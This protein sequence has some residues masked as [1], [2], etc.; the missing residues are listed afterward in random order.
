MTYLLYLMALLPATYGAVSTKTGTTSVGTVQTVTFDNPIAAPDTTCSSL[1]TF[2]AGD[3]GTSP[4]CSIS[5]STLDLIINMGDSMTPGTPTITLISGGFTDGL[6]GDLTFTRMSETKFIFSTGAAGSHYQDYVNKWTVVPANGNGGTFTYAWTYASGTGGPSLP[7]SGTTLV[8]DFN[9]WEATIGQ[10]YSVAVNMTDDNNA[11][12]YYADTGGVFTVLDSC[13]SSCDTVTWTMTNDPGTVSAT[14]TSGQGGDT[15]GCTKGAGG[16]PYQILATYATTSQGDHAGGLTLL[17]AG[18]TAPSGFSLP[19]TCGSA[20]SFPSVAVNSDAVAIQS[21][22]SQFAFDAAI[23]NRGLTVTTHYTITWTATNSGGTGYCGTTTDS[24]TCTIPADGTLTAGT[25]YA[26]TVALKLVCKSSIV[27]QDVTFTTFTYTAITTATST[28]G[29][30]QTLTFTEPMSQDIDLSDTGSD[31]CGNVLT[32]STQAEVGIGANCTMPDKSSLKIAYGANYTIGVMTLNLKIG[33]FDKYIVKSFTRGDVPSF[34]LSGTNTDKYED[35]VN[36]WSVVSEIN[37]GGA[38]L[39]YTWTY[40]SGTGGPSLAGNPTSMIFNY[41]TMTAETYNIKVVQSDTSNPH[42]SYEKE[43][44]NFKILASCTAASCTDV[45][46]TLSNDPGAFLSTTCTTGQG[47]GDIITCAKAQPGDYTITA[48]YGATSEGSNAGL[49]LL[50]TAFNPTLAFTLSSKCGSALSFPSVAVNSDAVA[51]QSSGSQFAFDAAI[52]NRGLTVTTHYTITWTATNSGGTG[53]CGTTTDSPTCTIPA[54]GTLTAGTTYAYTVALKLVCKSSIVWQDVTFTTFTY[55]A[56]TTAT[57]TV[58]SVQTLT[59]TEP[60][61]Q[62]IDLSDTGS[63]SCGNVLT[64]STQAEVGIG[65]NCTMPDKSSLKI[66]YGANYTIGVMTLNLKIGGFDKYIVKSFTRGDVPSFALSGTNTDKYEDYVNTWSVVSEINTGGAPLVYTWTYSS[67]TGGPSLAGNPTSMIF[68]YWT[69]TAETYN[70]K[71]VQSDTSNPHFSYEKETGNFKILA[72]C[73]AASC[74]DVTWTL[75]NDPGAFLST[76]CTTGQGGG[77]IITCA[78]AQPGDYT[79]TATYGATSEGSNAGLNLLST[80]FNPTLAFTLSSKCGSALS[81]P[82]V[83]VNSDAVAIQSSGSQFAFDAAITN[84][85]LTVTTHYT[86]TWTATNSGGTGYCGTT[87]DSPT[88][89][90]PADGTLT[91]GTT[92]AYTVALKLVCKSSIVWQDVTFTTFTYT[93]ITTATSTV[94]SVQTLTFTEPMSQSIALSDTGS[95]S[96]GNVLISSGVADVGTGAKCTTPTSSTLQIEY[97]N[98]YT[99]GGNLVLK[100]GGMDKWITHTFAKPTLPTVTYTAPMDGTTINQ[101]SG[102]ILMTFSITTVGSPTWLFTWECTTVPECPTTALASQTA[103]PLDLA[104]SN[105]KKGGSYTFKGTVRQSGV[106][107][108]LMTESITVTFLILLKSQTQIG[109]T[110]TVKSTG[111]IFNL[112]MGCATIFDGTDQGKLGGGA[113]CTHTGTTDTITIV[114][115][116]DTTLRSTDTMTLQLANYFESYTLNTFQ[117]GSFSS[118]ATTMKGSL[119]YIPLAET[120]TLTGG[121][122]STDCADY[123]VATPGMTAT[124]C[125]LESGGLEIVVRFA[126]SDGITVKNT[127]T[128]GDSKFSKNIYGK[129]TNEMPDFLPT[130]INTSTPA[131]GTTTTQDVGTIDMAFAITAASTKAAPGWTYSW[132]CVPLDPLASCPVMTG[133]TANPLNLPAAD[134]RYG[135]TYTITGLVKQDDTTIYNMTQSF[136]FLFLVRHKTDTQ[137]GNTI[138]I[139]SNPHIFHLAAMDCSTIFD[140][141]DKNKLGTG[142]TCTHSPPSDTITIVLGDD[143][144]LRSDSS[145]T[146]TKDQYFEDYSITIFQ[147]GSFSS[148]ATTMKGSLWYIP[149]AEVVTLTGAVSTDCADYF[150]ATTGMGAT[151]CHLESGG[152]EIVVRFASSD[153]ITG[154]NT[155]TIGDSKFNKNIYGKH[156]NQMPDFLPTMINTSTPADGTTTTQDVGT[157]IMTF[158][159]TAASTKAPPVWTYSWTC[160]PLDPLASCP[161]MTGYTAN[162]LNLPAADIRYGG[163]YTITGLVK[164][165]DTTIYN[166]T[167]SF[168]FLFLIK[169]KTDTQIGN[170]IVLQSAGHLFN[171]TGTDCTVIF[172]VTDQGLLGTG[173]TCTHVV[174]SDTITIVLGNDTSLRSTTPLTLTKDQYFEDYSITIFQ[175]GSFSSGATTMKGSLWYIPLAEVVTL[176]GAV[177]TDCAD[178]FVATTG[179]GAT[180]CHLESGGAEIVV[181]FAS[182]D[183]ITGKNTY[184]IGDSKF[185]KNIY[186]KHTNQMPDFLPTMIN[187]STPADGTTTTQDVGTIIM[188]FPITAASTKAPPVW[189]YSW[190]CVPL[191]P[192]ASCPVMTGYTANPLNL[193]AADIRY[194]GT[195]TIT[196]LV[197][198][199]DTTIY[200]MTQ[201][202]TFLFLIKMKTDTQ[203]GNT[204]VLQSAGH[205]FNLTGTACTV[206]FS[207]ADQAK[208]GTGATCTHVVNS[209]TITIVLGD[210]TTLR[211]DSSLTLT[212]NQYFEDYSITIFQSGSFSSGATTMKGSL[213]YIPLAEVVTLTGAVSTDCADYFVATTGMGATTCHLESGGAEIVVRFASSDGITGKNTYTIG[214]SKFNKNIYGKH[215]NQ[216]PDFLP[217]MINTSTPADGTTTTQDVGTIIMTFPITAASTKAPPVWTYS[218]TCVPLD[219]LA[220]CPVMTGYTAN[221]LNLPAADIRYGGTY[222]ITGLVKQDDTTIYNMTQSFT[223]LFLIKMKT[224]TQIGNTIVLQSAGHLFNLTGTACTVIFSVA[225][226]AKLGTGAT[227][228]HVVNS[229]TITIVLGDDT[230]LRSDSSLT[231]TK[232][233]YFEDYSITIFQSGSFSS[234]ATTMKGSLWYI[235]LA[236]VVT[237]TGAVSTDCADYFVATTG[238]GAT[239]CHLESGGAEIVVRFASSDG[240]TGK[241]TYTIGDSKFNKN[242]YGKHTNQMPDFLP[243]MINTSTP[244]DGTTTTQDVGTIIMTFPI[245]AA[246]TKAPPVWTYSWTCVPLDPLASCPVMTG[247]TANPLNLP[248]ADIR[249]GGTYTITGLVKQDD[250]TIYNMTQSFTFLFLIKMKTD[251]QIGNTIVLQSAG[252]LFN[253]TGTDCTVI[254]D[255]TDQGLLGTGATCTHVVNSDTITI[256]LGNDTSLRSTTPLTL[257]KDQYFEDYSITI[258]QSG[259]FSSGATTMKGSLWYIPLTEAVTVNGGGGAS[260]DCAD[261]FDAAVGMT[262]ST[263][264]LE[265]GGLEIVVRFASADAGVAAIQ[266]TYVISHSKFSKNIYGK[267]TNQMPDVVPTMTNASTP[268]DGATD[269]QDVGTV[270]MTFTITTAS[271]KAT[272]GWTYSWTCAPTPNCP[273]MTSYTANPLN[274]PAANIKYGG[275]FTI[276][277]LVKQTDTSIFNM[278]QSFS[279]LFLI[280]MKTDTQI[281]NTIVLQS[282]GHLFNLTGTACTVIFSV[283][284]QAKLG[285]GATCTHVVNSDTITIV[286]GDDTTLRSDSSL[287]L[288]KDQYF[289]D[290]SIT[291]FQSGSFSSGATT[292]KGSLWYIPLAEVVTLT[293]AVSTDC[294]DYFVATTGMG[295]TTCHLESGGAEIVVRFASSDGITGKN[296]YTIGDSKFNKNIYGK[297][298]NQ[299]PDFLPTMINTS[300]PADGTTTTQDVGTIIMT[301]PITAASTKAP[302]VW[303]YSWTCVPLDPLASCPVMTGYTANPL[304]LPAADI[305]YGGTYTITG[306]VKQDDTT[307][308]NMTQ[309]FTFLFL[310]RHKTDTQVGNTIIIK[311]NPHIFHLAAMDCSTIFDT[312]DKNKLGTGATCTHSPPSD[313]ITIVLGDDTTLRSDSSLTLTKDQYFE[314][315]SITIFQSGSFSS[316]ATTM[317]GSLW[318]I[319]LAEVVTLTGAVSTDCADYFVATT[320]MG[321]TTC[322]LES[323]GAEIVVRFASSDGITGK[324]TYTIGDS[325]FNKNIYGKHTNQ[326]P[327]FLPTMINTSTPADGTTT[328]QD[329]GTIIMTF[330][331]TA[332]STKAPPVWTY[333]WTCVP[334]DPLASCPVMT[335]YTAN[336]LNLPAA[337]IRYGGT[338]TITGLVKQDDTTIYNMTQSFTFLFLIKMKTDTQ[339][340]NTIVLQSAGHLFNL[341]GTDC[342]VIFD[343]TDQGLLGTGATCTHV[344]NSDT[345]T[346]VLGN[347]T[348]LRSTTPLTLTKDQ[349]FEDYLITIFHSGSFSSGATTMKGSLWYIPL[350][351]AVTVNGGGGASTDCADYFDAAVGM[352]DSTCV[353]ESGGLEIVVRFASADAG[354]AA[355]QNTYV[356]SH[357][358]FSKNI[359]GKHTNQMPDVVP[360]MTNA[361]TPADGATD[362]QDVGTVVMTFTITTASTK[363]TPGWTYSWTCAPLDPLA[364]CPVMT[365]YTTHPLNLPAADI[366]YGGTY[367]IT[368][369]VKQDDTTIYNMTQSFTFLFLIRM[370]TDTQIGNTIVLK[371]G[372]HL[373]NLTGTDCTVIF[374]VT[375]QGLLGTGA[376]CTHVVNSDTITIVL[377]NDTSLRS[378]TPLTLTKDQYF[379]DYLITIFHS[380]SFSSGATTMKGSLWYIP[381]TEAV[382]VNG[383]GGAS[384]DCADYFDA[385]VGMTDSTCV[386]ESGG[387]EIVVRFASADAGV[388]AIQNTYVISHSKFSKNIYGKHT[389]QMPDVV[390]T[391]TNASTPAD[392]ATDTQDVGTVVMTFSITAASTKATPSWTYSW[393]CA[394]LDP[395]ASCPVMTGYTTHPLNLPAADI[396]YGGTYTITGLVKQDDTTIYNMTQSFT[397]LFLIR[398]KTDTQIGNTIVLKSGGHLFNLTGTDCTV[399]FDITDQGLL[400]TG[401]TCT[402]VVNSDTITIVLGNDTS[403]R[404]TTPLTLTKDQYFEDY[405]ITIFHSGSFS[406]GATTMKGSLWYIPLTE[407]V[408][409]NGGGGASTDCADY[410]DAAVGMTDSTCVL[411]SGGLEIVVRFASADAGV[412]A[413]QNTYVISHSKFSKNIYGKHTNQMP[414]VVPTMTYF[415]AQDNIIITQDINNIIMT[416]TITAASTKAPPLWTYEWTCILGPECPV[417]TGYT[418]NPLTVPASTILKGGT[419]QFKVVVRQVDTPIYNMT[420]TMTTH[421][422]VRLKTQVPTGNVMVVTSSGH[423]FNLPG[424]DCSTIFDAAERTLL[425]TVISSTC[426][427]VDGTDTITIDIPDDTILTEASTID[428]ELADYFETYLIDVFQYGSFSYGVTS[429]KGSIWYIPLSSAVTLSPDD[430]SLDCTRYLVSTAGL[431]ASTC[432][433]EGGGTIIVLRFA[434]DGPSGLQNIYEILVA[435]Y[436][437]NIY[438][439]HLNPMPDVMPTMIFTSAQHLQTF[440]QDELN[441]IMKLTITAATGGGTPG[442]TYVWV[443]P[444]GPECPAMGGYTADPLDVLTSLIK[445]G[446]TYNFMGTAVQTDT[447]V[448]NMSLTMEFYYEIRLKT[449]SQNGNRLTVSTTG[450]LFNFDTF[451]CYKLFQASEIAKLGTVIPATCIHTDETDYFEII[452]PLT[453]IIDAD[454]VLNVQITGAVKYFEDYVI[455]VLHDMPS[456]EMLD[457]IIPT[458]NDHS[459]TVANWLRSDPKNIDSLVPSYA[460]IQDSGLSVALNATTYNQEWPLYTMHLDTAY[461]F[462]VNMTLANS[463]NWWKVLIINFDVTCGLDGWVVGTDLCWYC[464]DGNYSPLENERCITCPLRTYIYIYIYIYY[465][466]FL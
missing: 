191:D 325:K 8:F 20:L 363:A 327:D 27:W 441:V 173:A 286:L 40:S 6:T 74:T 271:T 416:L 276:T 233:Q 255:V 413:I 116:D 437:K 184:T 85:G 330:P 19:A 67:G 47:G 252:H 197:K 234:G 141:T 154:K 239:T 100:T 108:Y 171:L 353:L 263:C 425:G 343:V 371:S 433:L 25:T 24:P 189:T 153:G 187:T 378:T 393:T 181:R 243:T 215:T 213:W 220:S 86:I 128:I 288:T 273:V 444:V 119:W 446:G 455:D 293:G 155:Y 211:S 377:G 62:D 87:T 52:T 278:T 123:F 186:G 450:H 321:A 22:G 199:D 54:D 183:G 130:M 160:V 389:N 361:S 113:A 212:K 311:S 71:V 338:Y 326:M 37:T 223:F 219:P 264:V 53:Y 324:N 434:N 81:F 70:I 465:R 91:A 174:N 224:D 404:S 320:G 424:M 372:G 21:S 385:A 297:H 177:S 443:C 334:L 391:M 296:T 193:P 397:F 317:K 268:A 168:T 376:T 122:V 64:S 349:Y 270:V 411:E 126:S 60:M 140:T 292:M 49:N 175:S 127:Y 225:D 115:G 165:D 84:R 98:G 111:H 453:T 112:A 398:M 298:T 206:I 260:T 158:P 241:N 192:L 346:I 423:N 34:A 114:L 287:T 284:D 103:N 134:I 176:T 275:S 259:S 45:T 209:D 254:F 427:H 230:T 42:F 380:G 17:E 373:F 438:G 328:T 399:I 401:A 400:G 390:P 462:T 131:D 392:G 375:D 169:M 210:D 300:T 151:T 195:Y 322:H 205:L 95:D 347:D 18:F 345:I 31:S 249:Y 149:L 302:P 109:N 459:L 428:I 50:S 217:T 402:H 55:T 72:S 412:A 415:S 185:N 279:F 92:Y 172:D 3:L 405:L 370:K 313:T 221:P 231:L 258:F 152:A 314:D 23:T 303:T 207:V 374:D 228:T 180:T 436:N 238:M 283:A 421:F 76:T 35:Y 342:T 312:T 78:K 79:I 354:V 97:G 88:C 290:Y 182:S 463:N 440:T 329:V 464:G 301:F 358:K 366:R 1:L 422:R 281:G 277:G 248:A 451:D 396:R 56:I 454:S 142:A 9:Y 150:V 190:T 44:G 106:T 319:P 73:T 386:L 251:T 148:G 110:I 39:V 58:G 170:T 161:V 89:T 118:G 282:A 244:A 348:S 77:D 120:V 335:G 5:G 30:V 262:D 143:T 166:M 356:I 15:V 163:T 14:C 99:V 188:T 362:T 291:I 458:T 226:Q 10:G 435:G 285:T 381:L 104:T 102:N 368:G 146:L 167:Q 331:I 198:Q 222:T 310:V 269:T 295:A 121:A 227:C 41:W 299:M 159:I 245:T 432:T 272:P 246:S 388:A 337:D 232:N 61:S 395:L 253:L 360:T 135:G 430:G 289:E 235:P 445:K 13:A 63:D 274:L 145:L 409:V 369:L 11:Q 407:A 257:T 236:E 137:V 69:M 68:N 162:P 36:T 344:V 139:K 65:A 357:S 294:A 2:T 16:G 359:Y 164:Q 156:T 59:F 208:L 144:T 12:F 66:A 316:G 83:A 201:S 218:W 203:I 341:T 75:S 93:A 202:F 305:R 431:G 340:G 333:S 48:T 7:A 138:I 351:E 456:L 204:I 179:M 364:S 323:G 355:I 132:T 256:V 32:S 417:M 247:Y 384:T 466:P 194:G 414:D 419:Y 4:V 38:P 449:V 418:V 306:L 429:M 51:I 394:P 408:T 267:H 147:S 339:I 308:Y 196:G 315:Y 261:Y 403:L 447:T 33:G 26:Y 229:D 80:A 383:G 350:T 94:G 124:T 46:W 280:R 214:D 452:A 136:T 318:Y 237:L 420:H 242:I 387:L 352:T 28:V 332:A 82:S 157:I 426:T 307:I 336:P 442:W 365:G 129:H 367:T 96:C 178:Y 461:Q 265:S 57:S 43:T 107:N 90:I 379:E 105:L 29:S 406:S 304:N 266:N 382:T 125:H 457:N 460:W 101:D 200:N 117:A 410:F 240:I 309:S 216:M 448:F 439:Y 133:Y 250:T